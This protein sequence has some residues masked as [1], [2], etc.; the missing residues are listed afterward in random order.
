MKY[1]VGDKVRIKKDLEVGECYDGIEFLEKM[2]KMRGKVVTVR[3]TLGGKLLLVDEE[4]R[5][6][7]SLE[8]FEPVI[9]N[10]DKIKEMMNIEDVDGYSNPFCGAVHRIWKE[11]NCDTRFCNECKEWLK[12]PYEEPVREILDKEEKEYLSAVIKPFRNKNLV[13][14]KRRYEWGKEEYIVIG[15]D[16]EA[17][18]FPNF[19]EDTM[20]KG[21]ELERKYTLGELG[22]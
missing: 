17:L 14:S 19:E 10:F 1:K 12:Q 16:A 22:L 20:Y 9:T 21:M 7:Y 8:M 11:P 18:V 2:A 6:V 4:K 5:F 15:F 3:N 13:I